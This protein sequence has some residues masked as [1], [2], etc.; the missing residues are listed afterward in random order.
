MEDKCFYT[1]FNYFNIP[2]TIEIIESEVYVGKGV[3]IHEF[4]KFSMVEA[5]RFIGECNR[6]LSNHPDQLD[7]IYREWGSYAAKIC[8]LFENEFGVSLN[9]PSKE[10]DK[11]KI[12]FE[13]A[14]YHEHYKNAYATK[15][16]TYHFTLENLNHLINNKIESNLSQKDLSTKKS[17]ERTKA[18][19]QDFCLKLNDG[20]MANLFNILIALEFLTESSRDDFFNAFTGRSI[21]R[22]INWGGDQYSLYIL[23]KS[24][25]HNNFFKKKLNDGIWEIVTVIFSSNKKPYFNPKSLA[26]STP[27]KGKDYGA[28]H[29]I[30]D[31][32][33]DVSG[34]ELED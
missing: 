26:H 5:S 8:Y 29:H 7:L 2:I 10:F 22:K 14:D 9:D 4:K 19:Q 24:L 21:S 11:C 30:L 15:W 6:N 28:I 3:P 34:D 18:R 1:L 17:P 13:V 23:I 31:E 27:T 33:V 20:Q 32:I 12:N 16:D 25:N